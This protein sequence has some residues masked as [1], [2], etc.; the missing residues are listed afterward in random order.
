MKLRLFY[1]LQLLSLRG[2]LKEKK[3][4]LQEMEEALL[5]KDDK[6]S[7][8]QTQ[9]GSLQDRLTGLQ[10]ICSDDMYHSYQNTMIIVNLLFQ[11]QQGLPLNLRWKQSKDMPVIVGSY[12][13]SVVLQGK[14]YVSGESA[15]SSSQTVPYTVIEYDPHSDEWCPLPEYKA[16]LFGMAVLNGQLVLVGGQLGLVGG[17]FH[18]VDR[19]VT[20][21]IAEWDPQSK[22]WTS[23]TYTMRTGRYRPA[24]TTYNKWLVVAGGCDENGNL[25][26][27][28]I[29][30]TSTEQWYSAAPLPVKYSY[31]RSAVVRDDWYLTGCYD[32][33]ESKHVFSVSLPALILFAE[34]ASQVSSPLWCTLPN[35]PMLRSTPLAFH[36]SLL[37][38]GGNEASGVSSA[39]HLYQPWNKKWVKAGDLPVELSGCTCTELPSGKLLVVGGS[40]PRQNNMYTV[41]SRRVSIATVMDS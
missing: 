25:D 28:E 12:T 2:E 14:V 39:I 4:E 21:E 35:S 18:S 36:E 5:K 7:S 30:D 40:E 13:Y 24:V 22:N 1:L 10:V 19:K 3:D 6:I 11:A 33:A 29:L 15:S 26:V 31:M 17:R 23:K 37:A 20:K 27:V 32:K 9:I 8:L 41:S 38:V 34:T 16:M